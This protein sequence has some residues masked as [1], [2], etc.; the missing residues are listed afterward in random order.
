MIVL[1]AFSR[2]YNKLT[3]HIPNPNFMSLENQLIYWGSIATCLGGVLG[4]YYYYVNSHGYV[5][6]TTHRSITFVKGFDSRTQNCT[7]IFQMLVIIYTLLPIP[8]IRGSPYKEP[9]WRNFFLLLVIIL[10][11]IL[12][13]LIFFGTPY[14]S[15]LYLVQIDQSKEAVLYGIM[16]AT[17][18]VCFIYNQIIKIAV[19]FFE[20]R[21]WQIDE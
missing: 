8:I 17:M 1:F 14:L 2:A 18:A 21:T 20:E 19:L 4:A 10:N 12:S 3:R 9:I 11:F 5:A 13:T 16:M 6:D 7:I 15:F